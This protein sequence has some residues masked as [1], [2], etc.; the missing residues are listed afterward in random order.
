MTRFLNESPFEHRSRYGCEFTGTRCDFR[1]GV[2]VVRP[3]HINEVQFASDVAEFAAWHS[4]NIW[5]QLN[6]F[7]GYDC[8]DFTI[9][10]ER[11]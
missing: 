11:E 4:S 3:R 9:E 5:E 1:D 6:G 8:I 2:R 10:L 7:Q